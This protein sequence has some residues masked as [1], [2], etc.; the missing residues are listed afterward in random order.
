MVVRLDVL[1][2]VFLVGRL[3]VAGRMDDGDPVSG[4]GRW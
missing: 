3:V 1:L 2:V 4:V